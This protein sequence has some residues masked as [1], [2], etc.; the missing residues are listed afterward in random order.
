LAGASVMGIGMLC[1]YGLGMSKQ[2][3]IM[4]QSAWVF[5]TTI[6]LRVL[7]RNY[8]KMI[9]ATKVNKCNLGSVRLVN[10]LIRHDAFND[11]RDET[12]VILECHCVVEELA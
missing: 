12:S 10:V 3:S 5:S 9:K 6:A 2:A 4:S 8:N 11:P 1:Y 7:L